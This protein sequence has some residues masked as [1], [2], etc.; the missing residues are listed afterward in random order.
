MMF[1]TLLQLFGEAA[2]VDLMLTEHL[3]PIR[4]LTNLSK[5]GPTLMRKHSL[6]RYDIQSPLDQLPV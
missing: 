5:F 2:S 3:V 6:H 1:L 4:V